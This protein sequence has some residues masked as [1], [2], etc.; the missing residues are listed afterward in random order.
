MIFWADRRVSG[1]ASGSSR[2]NPVTRLA[3]TGASKRPF[4]KGRSRRVSPGRINSREPTSRCEHSR[5]ACASVQ[6]SAVRSENIQPTLSKESA[7]SRPL[8]SRS[9]LVHKSSAP[10]SAERRSLVMEIRLAHNASPP[11][12][13]RRLRQTERRNRTASPKLAAQDRSLAG[14]DFQQRQL[15][16]HCYRREGR[17]SDLQRRRRADVGLRRRRRDEQDHTR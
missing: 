14:R 7:L 9:S 10:P 3:E 2:P 4:A 1:V 5:L 12:C 8:G 11:N 15:F 13:C 6:T 17:H 16:E